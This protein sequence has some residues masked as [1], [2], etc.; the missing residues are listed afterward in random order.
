MRA[1]WV[2]DRGG[3]GPVSSEYGMS[4]TVVVDIVDVVCGISVVDRIV[5]DGAGV[6]V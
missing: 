1:A 6:V 3:K 2:T 5:V 4:L